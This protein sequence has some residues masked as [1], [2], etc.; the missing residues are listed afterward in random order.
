VVAIGF[1]AAWGVLFGPQTW[2]DTNP[3]HLIQG[4]TP[5]QRRKAALE[6]SEAAG[7]N[8]IDAVITS[9]VRATEDQ[10]AV[11]RCIAADS[12]S[13]VV[14]KV[15]RQRAATPADD[16]K[17][18][19]RLARAVSA[20]TKALSDPDPTVRKSAAFG[21][22]LLG[23]LRRLDL[24]EELVG[25][26]SDESTIVREAAAEA[27]A[28][29]RPT[30]SVVPGLTKALESA[31]QSVRNRAAVLLGRVGPEAEPAVPALI[32]ILHEPFDREKNERTGGAAWQW[33][34]ACGA[35]RSLVQISS[36][37]QV[38]TA[39]VEMLSS[40]VIERAGA[41]AAGLA[42]M[43]PRPI[44]AVAALLAA[45][46]RVL[47]SGSYQLGQVEISRSLGLIAADTA[48]APAAVAILLRGLDSEDT[49][50]RWGAVQAL[51]KFGSEAVP[52]VPKLRAIVMSDV[53]AH[54]KTAAEIA[55]AAIEGKPRKD[56]PE[57]REIP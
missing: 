33:D 15:L 52:A 24:P 50:V 14:H 7:A 9:L 37:Q 8:D 51:G 21:L 16:S 11:A 43:E 55:L 28:R 39:L 20:L 12:L 32:A 13:A 44:G 38:I 26:L 18:T 4:G 45:Y 25:M 31:D 48:S 19:E 57:L 10:D 3:L 34:P 41:A 46:D 22:G 35:A 54:V 30:A 6:L 29:A 47:K 40:D 17:S 56:Q 53:D 42:R 2:T 5:Q 36:S 23:S 27:L 49:M 1:F